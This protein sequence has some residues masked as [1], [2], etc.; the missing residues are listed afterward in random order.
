MFSAKLQPTEAGR[1]LLAKAQQGAKM[2]FTEVR[3]GSG[4]LN[5]K[6]PD[7]LTNVISLERSCPITSIK[8]TGSRTDISFTFIQDNTYAYYFRELALMARDPDVGE[9]AYMYANDG[10]NAELVPVPESTVLEREITI[11]VELSNVETVTAVVSSSMYAGKNEFDEHVADNTRHVTKAERDSWNKKVGLGS[12]GKIPSSYLPQQGTQNLNDLNGTLSV[13]K[14]GTGKTSWAENRIIYASGSEALGQLAF[15]GSAGAVLR[16]DPTGAPYWTSMGELASEIGA[17]TIVSGSY[18]GTGE[19]KAQLSVSDF[20]P[21]ARKIVLPIT[22][23]ILV[24]ADMS[25]INSGSSVLRQGTNVSFTVIGYGETEKYVAMYLR[26]N[27]LYV[28]TSIY[29]PGADKAGTQYDWV[30]IA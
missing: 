26:D 10:D 1:A 4:K 14:G 9:I 24:A 21:R 17:A 5:G 7:S 29:A 3:I 2:E 19:G 6:N 15:P 12:D 28:G 16:Q 13:K 30:A 20:L 27:I 25:A 23:K 18:M 22:P 8:R 11:I